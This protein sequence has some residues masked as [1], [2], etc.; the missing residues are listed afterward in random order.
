[1]S[2]LKVIKNDNILKPFFA[3]NP[4][5]DILNFNWFDKK[6]VEALNWEGLDEDKICDRLKAYQRLL[7][8]G[9]DPSDAKKLLDVSEEA[10]QDE[11]LELSAQEALQDEGKVEFGQKLDSALAIASISEAEFVQTSKLDPETAKETHRNATQT[12]QGEMLLL[13]NV[14]QVASPR[15]GGMLA[16]NTAQM[17]SDFQALPSY[18][19]LFGSLDYLQCDPCQSIFSPAAYFVDLMRLV[20]QYI[21]QPNKGNKD[22]VGL[23]D[24]RPDLENIPLTCD[25]T[26]DT[27]PYVQIVNEVLEAALQQGQEDI[28]QKLATQEPEIAGV[29]DQSL[30]TPPFNIYLQQ[31]RNYLGHLKTDLPTIYKTFSKNSQ[32]SETAWAREVIGLSPEEYKFIVNTSW[33]NDEWYAKTK[34]LVAYWPLDEG[35]GNT[36]KDVV[37]N[38]SGT[39]EHC[40]F[41]PMKR[42]PEWAEVTDFPEN[43]SRYVL[44]LNKNKDAENYVKIDNSQGL[45]HPNCTLEV[46]VKCTRY[47]QKERVILSDEGREK[48][49]RGWTGENVWSYRLFITSEGKLQFSCSAYNNLRL[50]HEIIE[51]K[52]E[53]IITDDKWHYIVVA[54]NHSEKQVKIYLDG[55]PI[56][57][58]DTS[59]NKNQ[60]HNTDN[61]LW[62]GGS[63]LDETHDFFPGQLGEI[64]IWDT[65]LSPEEIKTRIQQAK[66]V[67]EEKR[68]KEE[69]EIK[70]KEEYLAKKLNLAIADLQLLRSVGTNLTTEEGIRQIAKIKQFQEKYNLPLDVLCSFWHDIP[71]E[72]FDEEGEPSLFYRL[73]NNPLIL[74]GKDKYN[75]NDKIVWKIDEP[76]IQSS[77]FGRSRLLAGLQLSDN[78]LTDIAKTIWKDEAEIQLDLANLSWLFRVS[79]IPKLL[80]LRIEEY[81][82]LLQFLGKSIDSL[83]RIEIGKL[84]AITDFAEWLKVSGFSVYELNYIFNGTVYPSVEVLLLEEKMTSFMESLWHKLH[85]PEV[86]PDIKWQLSLEDYELITTADANLESLSQRYDEFDVLQNLKGLTQKETFLK[87][88]KLSEQELE[89]LLYQNLSPEEIESG[90]AHQ[91]YINKKLPDNKY[92]NLNDQSEIE[93]LNLEALDRV[94]RFLRLSRKLGGS[95]ADLD[96]VVTFI[97]ENLT[98]FNQQLAIHFNIEAGLFPVLAQLGAQTV[99]AQ[100]YIQLLLT[101]VKTEESNWQKIVDCLKF[102]SRMRLLVSKLALTEKELRS[103]SV[104]PQTHNINSLTQLTVKDIQNLYQWK[105]QLVRVFNGA[106]GNLVKYFEEP[107]EEK[108]AKATGWKEEQIKKANNFLKIEQNDLFNSVEGLLKLKQCF[109]LCTTIGCNIDFLC[110]LCDKLKDISAADNWQTYQNIAST[111]VNMVKAKYDD[112]TWTSVATKLDGKLNEQKRDLLTNLAFEKKELKSLRQLS[113]YLLLDVEMTSCACNSRI[114]LAILSVQTYLQ[115]CRMGL[116]PGVTQVNIPAVWWEWIMN[117]RKWEANRKVFLYPENYID[118]SLRKNASPIFKELQDELL[119]SEITAETVEA[120]Y[121]NYFDKFAELAKLQIVDGCRYEV[122]TPKSPEPTDTLFIFAKTI[123]QPQT[124]YYRRCE[125]PEAKKPFWGYWEKIDLQINSDYLAP[126]YAFNRLFVFWVETKEIEKPKK[127]EKGKINASQQEQTTQ[128]TIKYSFLNASQK[129]VSPQTLVADKVAESQNKDKTVSWEQVYPLVS[130]EK[131]NPE[132]LVFFGGLPALA[133]NEFNQKKNNYSFNFEKILTDDF[134]ISVSDSTPTDPSSCFDAL[135]STSNLLSLSDTTLTPIKYQSQAFILQRRSETFLALCKN[136][137][138]EVF[139][140]NTSTIQQFSRTLFANGLNGLLSLESQQILEP[141][142]PHVSNNKLDFDGAYGAYFWEIF[143]HIPFLIASTL[144]AHQ[145]YNEARQ[146]YQYIFNPTQPQIQ[147][148]KPINYW[149]LNEGSGEDIYDKEGNNN[150]TL[151]GNAKWKTTTDFPRSASRSVLQFDGISTYVELRTPSQLQLN[152]RDFTLEAWVKADELPDDKDSQEKSDRVI[153]STQ[154]QGSANE[155]LHLLIRNK[156]AYMGFWS[157]DLY[158]DIELQAE[159]WYHIVWRYTKSIGEQ[160]IFVNGNL[161]KSRQGA[162]SFQGTDTVMIGRWLYKANENDSQPGGYFKGQIANV[163]IWNVALNNEQIFDSANNPSNRFWRFLPFRGHTSEKLKEILTNEAAIQAYKENP[164]DPHAIARLRIGAYEKAVVMKYIDNLLNWGDALFTQDNWES[165]T[166]ATTLYLL[167]YD[168]LGSKPKNVGKPPTPEPKTFADIKKGAKGSSS[169]FLIDL[170]NRPEYQDFIKQFGDAVPFNA[171]DAYFCVSENQEF[172]KYWDRVEDRLFKIRHCQNIKG[173]ERQLA[174]FQPPIDPMQLV[175]QAAAGDSALSLPPTGTV[176]HYRFFHLLERAKGMA[177]TVIQLGSTLLNTLEKKDAEELALLRATQEPVLLQLI[178]KTKEKQIQEAEANLTSL[179]RSLEATKDRSKYYQNLIDNGWNSEEKATVALMGA[180]LVPQIYSSAIRASAIPGYLAPKIFGLAAGGMEFGDAINMAASMLDSSAGVLNQSASLAS[181]IG[182]FQRRKEDW[183]FQQKMATWD[184][185][186]IEKQIEAAKVRVDLAKAEIDVHHKSIEQSRQVE[187]F[188]K[189]RFT[190]KDLYQW[191]VGRLSGLYF[192]TYKIALEMAYSAQKA[193]QY[194]LNKDEDDTYLQPT[195]W[196]SYKKGLLAGE[197]LMLGLNQLEKAY[198]DG[199]DRCLEIEKIISLRQLDPHAFLALK[200]TGTCQFSFDE[201]LFALDFPSHYCRQIKTISVSIPAVVGPYQNI[202]ATLAQTSNKVLIKPDAKAVE[203]LLN[204]FEHSNQPDSKM[205]RQDWRNN[206]QIAISKGVNDSG[207]FVLNFQDDRYL[208]FEGTGAISNWKLE[209]PKATNQIDFDSITDVIITL[210]YTALEGGSTISK[211][212]AEN[213]KKFTGQVAFNLRRELLQNSNGDELSFVVSPNLFRG[214]L[215]NYSISA[216]TKERRSIY[217]QLLLSESA[218][219]ANLPTLELT[220]SNNKLIKLPLTKNENGIV[221]A[222]FNSNQ[223]IKNI[224]APHWSLSVSD[225][226]GF[227]GPQKVIDIAL[228]VAYEGDIEWPAIRSE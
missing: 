209:M 8:L 222:T 53:T 27:V 151:K 115:R 154:K 123:T 133:P 105:N 110:D 101:K 3:R 62:L 201:K 221:S 186:Q 83:E 129:W 225:Q 95:F 200:A 6:A 165:I 74:K 1:M 141:D 34:N 75:P 139:R 173:I 12:T 17:R 143:F 58:A 178:T 85:L 193:Y 148:P 167:A 94:D 48:L 7:R 37:G 181:T 35:S 66:A 224:F 217:L 196:D 69:Q 212:V 175:R 215:N 54:R 223:E 81:Q 170:E 120:A 220:I 160:A 158:G 111:V 98:Q 49:S 156:K 103:I 61:P 88:T 44:Q 166:Q 10:V 203:W 45:K 117:Y 145:R 180:A 36:V 134:L 46:W 33:H 19:K 121:R 41:F 124:F 30:L 142:F 204:G 11:E 135:P 63:P 5:F 214:N 72:K 106:E 228:V 43:N 210:S 147:I 168:L 22:F 187:Q 67:I 172:A 26:Q 118:P 127:T 25:N 152:N 2:D 32:E 149:L 100:G 179:Q 104:R 126:V 144:N 68:K 18:Q 90:K 97:E 82:L 59:Y 184:T 183:E 99:K 197:S 71:T 64:R 122:Q 125:Q 80:G 137:N 112:K 21:T 132:I 198:L 226:K 131:A 157:D 108:L 192:Q 87:Q 182:Q 15:M 146:W 153:L 13:A 39:F 174:L 89:N 113:E 169:D 119:Q 16:D 96:Q 218:D 31:I 188:F 189:D 140:L 51:A 29:K 199:S 163:R 4:E 206:Q 20:D 171:L 56:Q 79:K 28:W 177:S 211:A 40:S 130:L 91:F 227:F 84:I 50:E 107:S 76:A 109:D 70:G 194:E 162:K 116:E 185:Q 60:I 219:Q 23:G 138:E 42:K 159:K 102:I 9:L 14:M 57:T 65:A 86:L 191:M 114:Q 176:P 190:N 47:I 216:S 92:L 161:D 155:C 164:F 207:L 93:N 213:F 77:S 202:N 52:T 24:R 150:G 205:L 128:A 38:K 136:K 55:K 73:F 208:P 78:E 195:Y